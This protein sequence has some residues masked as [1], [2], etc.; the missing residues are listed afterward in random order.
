MTL[1]EYKDK[2]HVKIHLWTVE[3]LRA[4][5]EFMKDSRDCEEGKDWALRQKPD[6]KHEKQPKIKF[7]G[8]ASTKGRVAEKTPQIEPEP[9]EEISKTGQ[10]M[11]DLKEYKNKQGFI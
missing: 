4:D 1:E 3:K 9:V 11:K 8:L 2:H 10:I 5:K 6:L 7:L